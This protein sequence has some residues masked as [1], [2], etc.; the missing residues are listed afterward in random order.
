MSGILYNWK[1]NSFLGSE[2]DMDENEELDEGEERKV[3]PKRIVLAADD[4]SQIT[5][6]VA[7][8]LALLTFSLEKVAGLVEFS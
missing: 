5:Y 8:L 6:K 7:F 1:K 2:N 4:D 3:L